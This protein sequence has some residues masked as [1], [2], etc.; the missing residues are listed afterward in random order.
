MPRNASAKQKK[1]E[2]Q[3]KHPEVVYES[4]SLA[5][6]LACFNFFAYLK[7]EGEEGWDPDKK[8]G[9]IWHWRS[10]ELI[11]KNINKSSWRVIGLVSVHECLSF[12]L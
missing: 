12:L 6:K 5:K 4:L 3:A 2:Y 11:K 7:S 1:L 8:Q 10:S 9:T